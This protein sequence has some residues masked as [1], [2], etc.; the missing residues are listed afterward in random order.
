T[1][2]ARFIA[3]GSSV[4]G[5]QA[6]QVYLYGFAY[7]TGAGNAT[8]TAQGGQASGAEGGL[9]D[10]FAFPTSGNSVAIAKPG[11]NGGLGG[12]IV[13]ENAAT[14]GFGRFRLLGNGLLDLGPITDREVSINSLEGDGI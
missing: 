12:H 5:A 10:F 14:A 2:G 8:F 7:D 1:N 9:L 13:V 11:T 4:A 3:K 6:G